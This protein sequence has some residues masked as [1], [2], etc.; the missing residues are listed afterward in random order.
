MFEL[1]NKLYNITLVSCF[2]N[3]S[4]RRT[5]YFVF[6]VNMKVFKKNN[7]KNNVTHLLLLFRTYYSTVV[8]FIYVFYRLNLMV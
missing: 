3:K 1:E 7:F 4:V 6:V 8:I 2:I 5:G